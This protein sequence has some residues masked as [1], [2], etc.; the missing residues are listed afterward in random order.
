V[1]RRLDGAGYL[2]NTGYDFKG[3]LLSHARQLGSKYKQSPDWSPLAAL[4]GAAALDAAAVAAGLIP[5]GDGGR[6]R[7]SGTSIY[8]AVNRVIQT[9]SPANP[10]M[11]PNV[12]AYGYDPGGA[13]ATVDAGCNR[14]LPPPVCSTR[15]RR[16]GIW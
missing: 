3:N 14:P 5:T 12:M 11:R 9:V 10:T 13:L 8:D 1:F 16:I 6:D 7:F 4:T 2:E 15:Q